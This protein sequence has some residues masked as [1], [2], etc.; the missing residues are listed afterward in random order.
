MFYI[1]S[2]YI[3]KPV[4]FNVSNEVDEDRYEYAKTLQFTRLVKEWVDAYRD[5]RLFVYPNVE[6]IPILDDYESTTQQDQEFDELAMF[7]TY[8]EFDLKQFM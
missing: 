2:K 5:G 3:N 8:Q 4:R 1:P 6:S 7:E